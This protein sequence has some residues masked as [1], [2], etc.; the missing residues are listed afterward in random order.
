MTRRAALL[1]LAGLAGCAPQGPAPQPRYLVGEPYQMGG[2]WSYPREDFGLLQTG[3]AAVAAD[4]RRGRRTANGEVHDP[5]LLTAA[6]RTLQMP[7][8]L[9]VTNLE[10]GLELEVRVNDRGPANPGRVLELSRRAA[11]LLG[12]PAGGTAQLRI[13]VVTGPSRA[14]AAG[15]PSAEAPP[16]QV[17]AAPLGAVQREDLA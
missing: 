2:V 6:H 5:A 9:R 10:N 12:I 11:E 8:I 14:L 16:L 4:T 7:A 1:L 13:A 3:L 17:A 15:L